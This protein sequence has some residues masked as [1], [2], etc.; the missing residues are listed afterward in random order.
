MKNYGKLTGHE[1]CNDTVKIRFANGILEITAVTEE[2]IRIFSDFKKERIVSKAVEG[3]KCQ[4][5]NLSVNTLNDTLEIRTSKLVVRVGENARVDI[6]DKNEK[7]LCL[8]Y[9]G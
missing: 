4:G 1:I 9:Q 5:V 6:Y 8:D 7:A 3:N 2:I